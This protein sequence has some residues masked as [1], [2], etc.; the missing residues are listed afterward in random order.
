MILKKIAAISAAAVLLLSSSA[1]GSSL[2]TVYDLSEEIKLSKSIAY[3]RIEKY[4]SIGWMNINVIRADLTDEYTEIK[5]INSDEG[6]SNRAALSSMVKSSGAVAAVNGD[7]FYMGDPTYTY[8]PLIRDNKLITSPLPFSDGYPTVSRLS[9]GS[10]DISVW[11]PKITVYGSDSTEFNVVVLNKTSSIE[12]GPTILTSD[13]NKTSPGYTTKDIVEVVV[14][15]SI[16]SEVRRNQPSTNIPENGYVIASSN[17]A[18]ME[19][20]LNS[21]KEGQPVSLNIELD[22]S[23][24]D[25]N[26]SFGALNYIVKDGMENE[27]S[28]QVLGAH[29]RTAIGFNKDN[30]EMIMVTIDGRHRDYVGAKQTELAKIMIDLGAYNAVNMDGGGSTTM[31]VDFLK[32]ANI[33]VVNIPS[34]GRERKI[35]SGVGVFNNYP[36][37]DKIDKIE[38]EALQNSIFNKTE[39]ELK[40]KFFNE[41]YTPVDADLRNVD[42]SVSPVGAGRVENNVFLPEKPGKA[43]ITAHA[44]NAEGQIE[45]NVLDN[46]VALELETDSLTLGFNDKYALGK[47]LGIDKDGNSATIPWKYINY[48]YRNRVG[49]VEDGIFTSNDIANTGAVTLTFGDAIKHIQVKVGYRYK[50]LNRFENIDNLKLTLY[51]EKSSGEIS[52]TNDFVKEGEYA[53]KLNYDFT[54]MTDQS[55]AFV[56]FGNDGEGIKLEDKPLAIGMWVYGDNKNHWLRTRITD[57]Y[58]TQVK[59]D[60]EEEV[61]WTGW[62]WVEAKIPE[63]IAYPITL[64][65]IYLAEINET[66]KDTGT[67]YIDNLR[68]MYEP[69][70]KELGLVDETQFIDEA[71]TSSIANYTEKLTI[72]QGEYNYE[73][74]GDIIYFEGIISNGTMS[75]SNVTMWNNIKSFMDYEDKVLVL[76]MNGDINNINDERE[77]KILKEILEKAS[78]KNNVFVVFNGEKENTVIENKVRYITYDDSFEIGITSG[79]PSYKN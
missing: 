35:A 73:G 6:V 38:I 51:P 11:N 55:I 3:E 50:T 13:W 16:V 62:K 78:Q 60:F 53:L 64:K 67:I 21:F 4:T 18:T 31:G 43:T 45:I 7:F 76:S 26:W 54:E 33:T 23:P 47:V 79:R 1:Y 70:D 52:V 68:I 72:S 48:S 24:E 28:S 22:F 30:T 66:R 59:I 36:D 5:P 69:K 74:N 57:A 77:I 29:P 25:V 37:S 39:T 41:Y 2:Y 56:E 71:K 65:N 42:F 10:V 15:D 61:N 14:V 40:L 19:Q 75:A 44:G 9:D 20:M 46:P 49:I 34:D 58:G 32:N 12:W 63:G 17:A 8:G 27:I